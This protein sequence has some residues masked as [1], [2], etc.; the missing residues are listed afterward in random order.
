MASDQASHRLL[1]FPGTPTFKSHRSMLVAVR[2]RLPVAAALSLTVIGW[3]LIWLIALLSST[4]PVWPAILAFAA[5]LALI[6]FQAAFEK[7]GRR[8]RQ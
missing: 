1:A 6:P 7:R 2:P 3:S 4:W 5:G 8:D